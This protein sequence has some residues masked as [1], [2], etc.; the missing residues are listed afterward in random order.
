[1]TFT[2]DL[3][4]NN[5]SFPLAATSLLWWC[6]YWREVGQPVTHLRSER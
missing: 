5:N 1:M 2:Y 6:V 3:I 4:Y